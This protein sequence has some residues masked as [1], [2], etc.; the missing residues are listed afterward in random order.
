[1]G[2]PVGIAAL[3]LVEAKTLKLV[4]AAFLIA[5]GAFF[6]TRANLPR[7]ERPTPVADAGV[8]FAGGV[9]GGAAALSGALPTMW[10]A[11]R[12]WPKA[13][14]RAVLQP[15]NV[16]ILGLA[17][18][19]LAWRGA[20]GRETLLLLLVA[21]PVGMIAAQGGIAAFRRLGDD[22]FRRLLIGLMLASGLALAV[23]ELA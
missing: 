17:I 19:M 13:E 10:C 1:M 16:A 6:A 12:P 8:G 5:Y 22:T 15:Y 20:Y 11:M 7:F 21:L 2:V 4:I 14:T 9:L 18:A 23:R 3:A